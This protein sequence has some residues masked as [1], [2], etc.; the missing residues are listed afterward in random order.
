[1]STRHDIK[2]VTDMLKLSEEEFARMLPDL[3]AWY[4]LGVDLQALGAEVR[5][6]IWVDDGKPGEIHHGE[7]TIKETGEKYI[8]PGSAFGDAQ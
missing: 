8:V 3:V 2:T 5:T 7:I 6:F 1:M 4:S